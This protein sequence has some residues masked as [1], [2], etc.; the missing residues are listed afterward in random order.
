MEFGY[1]SCGETLTFE[2]TIK[3]INDDY[4]NGK[5]IITAIH[6]HKCPKCNKTYKITMTFKQE[7]FE[8]NDN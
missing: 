7:D 4:H 8:D 2:K 5:S 1:C 3:C 6:K